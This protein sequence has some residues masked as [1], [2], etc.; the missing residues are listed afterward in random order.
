[1]VQICQRRRIRAAD[2]VW[3]A[4][5]GGGDSVVLPLYRPERVFAGADIYTR[6]LLVVP[7]CGG[8]ELFL[9]TYDALCDTEWAASYPLALSPQEL[10]LLRRGLEQRCGYPLR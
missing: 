5:E 7:L 8:P 10:R 9:S 2:I 1:M 6:V 3:E 4:A